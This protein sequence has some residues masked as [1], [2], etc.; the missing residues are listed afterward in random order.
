Q[1]PHSGHSVPAPPSGTPPSRVVG[2]SSASGVLDRISKRSGPI[3]P[4]Y[5]SGPLAA[6]RRPADPS[7]PTEALQDLEGGCDHEGG[8]EPPGFFGGRPRRRSRW[9][10]EPD[11]LT[12]A[13]ADVSA[14]S[15][16]P[17]RYT[18]HHD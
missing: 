12:R 17:R 8:S 5:H 3:R 16:D 14:V 9:V 1:Y 13:P 6:T 2:A 18:G 11:T 4:P 15:R 7:G 10:G